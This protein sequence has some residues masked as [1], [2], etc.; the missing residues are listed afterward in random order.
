MLRRLGQPAENAAVSSDDLA[1]PALDQPFV[2]EE[3]PVGVRFYT[4]RAS[5]F[6]PYAL[7]QCIRLAAD[8]LS[9]DFIG[10]EVTIHGRG[11]HEMYVL[12]ARQRVASVMEQGE[13]Y[14][15]A[16]ESSA[17]VTRIEQMEK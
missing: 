17:Y 10:S 14:S 11:L 9:L 1:F 16:S 8:K 3:R 2:L 5:F 6:R 13:R 15:V 12:L 7:L 4:G